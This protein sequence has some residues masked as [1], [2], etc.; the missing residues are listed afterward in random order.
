M[1]STERANVRQRRMTWRRPRESDVQESPKGV[2]TVAVVSAEG[3]NQML[4][5]KDPRMLPAAER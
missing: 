5:L 2:K 3:V 4:H 1:E